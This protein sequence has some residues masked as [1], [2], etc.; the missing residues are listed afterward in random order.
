MSEKRSEEGKTR[1]KKV[2]RKIA[3]GN[4]LTTKDK[5]KA[6]ED[7]ILGIKACYLK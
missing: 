5:L 2:G 3:K 6:E 4:L 1:G 7:E